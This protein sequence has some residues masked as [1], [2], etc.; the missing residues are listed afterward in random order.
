[1]TKSNSK[2]GVTRRSQAK[3]KC[4]PYYAGITNSHEF[5]WAMNVIAADVVSGRI[6][7]KAANAYLAEAR[8]TLKMVELQQKAQQ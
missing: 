3:P 8:L 4:A 2:N 1:M 6:S 5:M 7:T